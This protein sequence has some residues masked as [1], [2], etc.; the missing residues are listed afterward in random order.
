MI[1]DFFHLI[2]LNF[3]GI[4]GEACVAQLIND[5]FYFVNN[6]TFLLWQE[7]LHPDLISLIIYD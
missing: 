3:N 2:L 6:F 1:D 7:I 4:Q 5:F